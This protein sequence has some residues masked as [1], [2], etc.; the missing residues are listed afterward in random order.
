MQ[1][2]MPTTPPRTASTGPAWL[3]CAVVSASAHALLLGSWGTRPQVGHGAPAGQAF[4]APAHTAHISLVTRTVAKAA[5]PSAT[6]HV[7]TDDPHAPR[8][9]AVAPASADPA[10][11]PPPDQPAP[12][13][14]D[15]AAPGPLRDDYI[16]RPQLSVPPVAQAPVI[17]A[18]PASPQG[19]GSPSPPAR[20][21]GVLALFIDE[22][23]V[24]RKVQADEPRLPPRLEKAAQEAF[25]AARFSPGQLDGQIVKSRIRIEVVFDNT[26]LDAPAA[27]TPSGS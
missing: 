8:A 24:V 18:P 9:N 1:Q 3:L 14:R 13:T 20:H 25:L 15:Q 16:P 21:V 11:A 23:G 2:G 27:P 19:D 17:I 10:A 5:P 26:P 4:A 12:P 7:R 22:H 6:A